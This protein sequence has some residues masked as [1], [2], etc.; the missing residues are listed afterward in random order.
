MVIRFFLYTIEYYIYFSTDFF[1]YVIFFHHLWCSLEKKIWVKG[2]EKSLNDVLAHSPNFIQHT[3]P[4]SIGNEFDERFKQ[5]TF[6]VKRT[7]ADQ[8]N[9][10]KGI[11]ETI[12]PLLSAHISIYLHT[13]TAPNC[14]FRIRKKYNKN[15]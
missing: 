13:L 15:E 3:R 14:R 6:L 4:I 5:A 12:A 9:N 2:N 11:S 1:Q 10:M 7:V 8:W